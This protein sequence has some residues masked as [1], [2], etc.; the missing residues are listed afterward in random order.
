M[1]S[2][3]LSSRRWGLDRLLS[4]LRTGCDG[5]NNSGRLEHMWSGPAC[6][7]ELDVFAPNFSRHW[8]YFKAHR[9]LILSF[10]LVD[11]DID[12]QFRG[13]LTSSSS[14]RLQLAASP[15]CAPVRVDTSLLITHGKHSLR[16]P[17]VAIGSFPRYHKS[18][19]AGIL[20]ECITQDANRPWRAEGLRL[21][22]F[23][24]RT[25]LLQV[26]W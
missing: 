13:L 18:Y 26:V 23:R 4:R 7:A 19:I 1:S 10:N 21:S 25:H 17:E 8:S 5:R 24:P 20:Y 3:G 14:S 9:H 15:L 6:R 12:N 16:V 22:S 11:F 2:D